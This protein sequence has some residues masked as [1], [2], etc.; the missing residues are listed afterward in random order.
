MSKLTF[1]SDH[2]LWKSLSKAEIWEEIK[3]WLKLMK[4]R[5]VEERRARMRVI[6]SKP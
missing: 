5:A 2:N 4:A 3:Q 1:Q 6:S